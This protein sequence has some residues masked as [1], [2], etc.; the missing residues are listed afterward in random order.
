MTQ[1]KENVWI[2]SMVGICLLFWDDKEIIR[3]GGLADLITILQLFTLLS[4]LLRTW[5]DDAGDND[6]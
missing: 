5:N 4:C 3:I 2:N 6:E 1:G